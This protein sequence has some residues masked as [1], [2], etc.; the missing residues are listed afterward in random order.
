MTTGYKNVGIGLDTLANA[1]GTSNVAM[2]SEALYITT[3][4]GSIGIGHQALRANSTGGFNV[5]LGYRAADRVTTGSYN[6]AF[7]YDSMGASAGVTGSNNI[8][9]GAAAGEDLTTALYTISIGYEAGANITTASDNVAIGRNASGTLTTGTN[10]VAVG[11][12]ALSLNTGNSNTALGSSAGSTTTTGANT[13]MLGYNAEPSSATV[14]NE[15]TLGDANVTRFR[16]PGIGLD[17]T[18]APAAPAMDLIQTVDVTTATASVSFTGLDNTYSVYKLFYNYVRSETNTQYIMWRGTISGTAVEDIYSHHIIVNADSDTDYGNAYT[19]C[20]F[21]HNNGLLASGELTFYG[22]GESNTAITA[23]GHGIVGD[24]AAAPY[25]NNQVHAGM[26]EAQ[27]GT[28]NGIQI[29][30]LF[31][32]I[33]AG[34]KFNLYGLKDA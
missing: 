3:G 25:M 7:G 10:N 15:V 8:A 28:W 5:G 30:G 34:A 31:Y 24:R 14:S 17:W 29:V 32:N 2:G 16:I 4:F 23:Q 13:T 19:A 1:T 33:P 22:I 21:Q 27:T 26:G 20:A 18:A 6:I 11:P 12:T 9:I